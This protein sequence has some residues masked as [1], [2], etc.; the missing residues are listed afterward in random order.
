[1][2]S[3]RRDEQLCDQAVARLGRPDW[4]REQAGRPPCTTGQMAEAR[5]RLRKARDELLD[6]ECKGRDCRRRAQMFLLF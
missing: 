1:M 5:E 4:K 2:P 3:R 6:D